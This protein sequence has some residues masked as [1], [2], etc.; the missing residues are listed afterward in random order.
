M[1][2]SQRLRALEEIIR[3]L[4][5]TIFRGSLHSSG[6]VSK[7]SESSFQIPHINRY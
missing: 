3:N 5:T 1:T 7:L 6:S 2:G 4:S